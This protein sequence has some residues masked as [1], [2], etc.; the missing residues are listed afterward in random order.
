MKKVNNFQIAKVAE[1]LLDFCQFQPGIAYISVAYKKECI[2][3]KV[4]LCCI[5]SW[6]NIHKAKTMYNRFF[7]LQRE[8]LREVKN[9]QLL[10]ILINS[11]IV[12]AQLLVLQ[13]L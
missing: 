8:R 2:L 4:F 9:L 13:F 6:K 3:W 10:E 7:L 1:L 5:E 12:M 11:T